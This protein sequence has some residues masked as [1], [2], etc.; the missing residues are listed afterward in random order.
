M[1]FV[2]PHNQDWDN[3]AA[4][5]GDTSWRAERMRRYSELLED[6]RH[7]P[8]KRWIARLTGFNPARHGFDGSPPNGDADG[9]FGIRYLRRILEDLAT[10]A[11]A[12]I[13]HRLKRLHSFFKPAPIL[14]I[15]AR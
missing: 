7:R 10:D 2:Y 13:G 1:I 15:G 8:L 14:T 6:C 9:I 11:S 4:L 5:T 3:I 12:Q